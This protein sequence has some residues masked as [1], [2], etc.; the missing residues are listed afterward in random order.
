MIGRS[1]LE[2]GLAAA[3]ILALATLA[4]LAVW[5]RVAGGPATLPG[6]PLGLSPDRLEMLAAAFPAPVD[7]ALQWPRDHGA[8]PDQF[9]EAWSFAGLLKDADG[10]RHGFQLAFL[11][12]A[13]QPERDAQE[14]ASAWATREL[15]RARLVIAPEGEAAYAEERFARAALGLAGS[16]AEPPR[17]WLEDWAFRFDEADGVFLL[18]AAGDDRALALRLRLPAAPA[19]PLGGDSHRGYWWPALLAD[20]SLSIGGRPVAVSGTAMLERTWGRAVPLGAGQQALA[21]LW[22]HGGDGSAMRCWQLR[23]KAGGGTP[24]GECLRYGDALAGEVSMA[25][26]ERG[27]ETTSGV[28]F[29][30][31]WRIGV[32]SQSGALELAPLSSEQAS[33]AGA[34]WSGV[35]AVEGHPD[36]WGLLELS[37]FATP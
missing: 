23:R 5:L 12:I 8:K 4:A 31:R 34:G 13:L 20:G 19:A 9:V 10:G 25:P 11:R 14:R 32:P 24:L 37:N 6:V 33:F 26:L 7:E 16:G 15:Y 3:A 28:R 29:P 1:L 17:A 22:L 21:Q 18:R 27:W 36:A 35:L 30:L 2:R